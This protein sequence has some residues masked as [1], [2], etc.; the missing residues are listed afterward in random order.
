MLQCS[1]PLSKY[2]FE[3]IRCCLQSQGADSL[4]VLDPNLPIREADMS[5]GPKT[6]YRSHVLKRLART[7]AQLVTKMENAMNIRI[8]ILAACAST[9]ALA[10]S[11]IALAKSG[12]GTQRTAPQPSAK[13]GH[14]VNPTIKKNRITPEDHSGGLDSSGGGG[15]K[16]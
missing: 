15:K 16:K 12:G 4:K 1:R 9:L 7:H 3:P 6:M 13:V 11:D 10:Q 2:S 5:M 14:S 8:T